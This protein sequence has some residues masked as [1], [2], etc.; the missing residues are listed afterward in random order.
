VEHQKPTWWESVRP[1]ALPSIAAAAALGAATL[2]G[3]W[4]VK[5][6]VSLDEATWLLAFL[7]GVLALSVPF[8]IWDA[9]R[10]QED[11]MRNQDSANAQFYKQEQMRFY[12][13]LDA[14][15]LDIQKLVIQHPFLARPDEPRT[16]D[17]EVQYQAFAFIV[18][19][20][21]ESIDDYCTELTGGKPSSFLKD[22]WDGVKKYEAVLH[23]RW[24]QDPKSE[25]KFKPTFR[26]KMMIYLKDC[27][28]ATL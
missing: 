17:Q 4:T 16:A 6:D 9:T 22:T 12:A 19:N 8:S 7:T 10:K 3:A 26:Q 21:L 11:A 20:F 28:R 25:G 24:F 1:S 14:I 13:Q 23:A 18:W 5:H 27:G 15:Y 2:Y